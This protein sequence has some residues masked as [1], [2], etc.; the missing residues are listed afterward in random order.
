MT[1]ISSHHWKVKLRS[2]VSI[3][4]ITSLH[5]VDWFHVLR[6]NSR[7]LPD[8]PASIPLFITSL[9]MSPNGGVRRLDRVEG[10]DQV[11]SEETGGEADPAG[12]EGDAGQP[13]RRLCEPPARA[14]P[15]SLPLPLARGYPVHPC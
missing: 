8:V 10:G 11:Q 12:A 7:L 6:R 13:F 14:T 2:D 9:R 5:P 15:T 4:G 3:I 1:G